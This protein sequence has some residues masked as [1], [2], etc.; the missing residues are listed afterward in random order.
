MI[1]KV[2]FFFFGS[3]GLVNTLRMVSVVI[4]L[5]SLRPRLGGRE[6]ALVLLQGE[7][8]L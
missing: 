4:S 6:E 5:V 3:S 1:G 8:G 7:G 2:P